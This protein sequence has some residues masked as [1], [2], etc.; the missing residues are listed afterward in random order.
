MRA[1]N[2]LFKRS[3]LASRLQQDGHA[4][5][6]EAHPHRHP[7][8]VDGDLRGRRDRLHHPRQHVH[9]LRLGGQSAQFHLNEGNQHGC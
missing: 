3:L 6:G 1:R 9:D 8:A 5:R 2:D 7:D 4:A